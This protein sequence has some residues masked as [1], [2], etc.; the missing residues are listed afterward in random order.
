M[1]AS[2]RG[3]RFEVSQV[4]RE[5]VD[6]VLKDPGVSE[7]V[8][9]N[10][11]KVYALLT[12]LLI[13]LLNDHSRASFSSGRSSSPLFRTKAMRSVVSSSG[14]HD[15]RLRGT[16]TDTN[17]PLQDGRRSR[18]RQVEAPPATRSATRAQA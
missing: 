14:A 17:V 6:R 16:C 12:V 7:Q 15:S 4:L 5:V 10:R 13:L 8:L 1:L 3:T 9:Y 2:W 11:A 18:R